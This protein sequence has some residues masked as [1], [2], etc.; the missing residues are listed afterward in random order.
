MKIKFNPIDEIKLGVPEG[1]LPEIEEVF[2][3]FRGHY[4][5]YPAGNLFYGTDSDVED[6]EVAKNAPFE[7]YAVAA[8]YRREDAEA[9]I[10]KLN[11]D[12]GKDDVHYKYVPCQLSD[13][14]DP[15]NVF[16]NVDEIIIAYECK[17]LFMIRHSS[18]VTDFL[19][20]ELVNR[21]VA[22]EQEYF[23][24]VYGRDFCEKISKIPFFY[25]ADEPTKKAL[26]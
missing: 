14:F 12:L 8:Y 25:D 11:K 21:V 17:G 3:V 9:A 13:E 7:A 4:E 26:S 22:E 23:S 15:L 10:A 5:R 24:G 18:A 2:V 16:P 6:S 20:E 19:D 1:F